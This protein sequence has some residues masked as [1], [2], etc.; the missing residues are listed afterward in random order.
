[1][2]P[3]GAL[4]TIGISAAPVFELRGGL[5]FA[6]ARGFAPAWALILS[7]LGN[8]AVIPALLWGLQGAEHLLMRFAWTRRIL[9]WVFDRS[10]RRGRWVQR[11]G[12]LGLLLLVAV[13][14]PGTGAWTGAIVARLLGLPNRQA[15]WWIALGVLIASGIVLAA[16]LGVMTIFGI[17]SGA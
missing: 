17:G 6:L 5:P 12:M 7:L 10:R 4:L 8:L 15:V 1:M 9:T 16:S 3:L 13:P 11:F 2:D 14:A